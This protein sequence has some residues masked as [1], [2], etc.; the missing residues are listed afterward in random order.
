MA[1]YRHW[2]E[3]ADVTVLHT[4]IT[5]LHRANVEMQLTDVMSGD[6]PRIFAEHIFKYISEHRDAG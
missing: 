6:P 3:Q 1:K 4:D 2:L 5:L